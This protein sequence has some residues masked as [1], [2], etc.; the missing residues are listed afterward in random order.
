MRRGDASGTAGHLVVLE[1]IEVRVDRIV[2]T[3]RVD[4]QRAQTNPDIAQRICKIMPDLPRHVCVN[5]EGPTFG[6]VIDHTSLP[7]LLEHM[8]I[9]RETEA[10]T[11]LD[12]VLVGTTR[13]IDRAVGKACIEVAYADDLI[14]L[15]A[16]RDA[17][18]LL[19]S[20]R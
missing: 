19:D 4:P 9:D 15:C 10:S 3:V 8:V 2:A 20:L 17:V 13:W 14:A 18:E 16:F 1:S 6:A 11:D 7:H 12:R 5:G